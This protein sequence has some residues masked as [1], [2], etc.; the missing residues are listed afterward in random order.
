[1]TNSINTAITHLHHVV[2]VHESKIINFAFGTYTK[3]FTQLKIPGA[4][5]FFLGISFLIN[6]PE[7]KSKG[8]IFNDIAIGLEI[9]TKD[10]C[11]AAIH[12]GHTCRIEF[13]LTLLRAFFKQLF[14]CFQVETYNGG[15]RISIHHTAKLQH[16]KVNNTIV[17]AQ[18]IAD[19]FFSTQGWNPGPLFSFFCREKVNLESIV[20]VF[21]TGHVGNKAFSFYRVKPLVS[22]LIIRR[23][24]V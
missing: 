14:S 15:L 17:G 3:K 7:C 24:E 13:K 18:V 5:L 12:Y 16:L 22:I 10:Y 8:F 6:T 21:T 1:F 23:C 19:E 20:F 9:L 4:I 11:L 2:Q